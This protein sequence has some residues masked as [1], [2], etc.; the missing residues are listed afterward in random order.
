MKIVVVSD[1]HGRIEVLS[2]ILQDHA[3]A[4]AF[5]HCGDIELPEEYFPEFIKVRG[6]N[7]YYGNYEQERVLH[8]GDLSILITHSHQYVYYSRQEQL[9]KKASRLGCQLVCYG[10]THV[11]NDS[12]IDDVR[13]LNP[14]SCWHNR[15]GRNPSYAIVHYEDGKIEIERIEV[16]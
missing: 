10:H 4:R 7:D 6:N 9:A 8:V 12:V 5:I 14:G 16:N 2:Q 15:D 11:Y 3:D 1:S 13:L